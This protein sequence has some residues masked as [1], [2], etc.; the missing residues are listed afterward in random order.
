MKKTPNESNH[1]L[2]KVV[3]TFVAKISLHHWNL[4]PL[5]VV[6]VDDVGDLDPAL[7]LWI[8]PKVR[9]PSLFIGRILPG[10]KRFL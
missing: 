5:P 4:L 7:P 2:S 9:D 10:E 3:I 6:G 8:G 1:P